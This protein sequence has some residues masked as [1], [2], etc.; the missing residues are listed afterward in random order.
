MS[1]TFI[2]SPT[3]VK[4]GPG[5]I[6]TLII[7]NPNPNSQSIILYDNTTGNPPTLLQITLHPSRSPIAIQFQ[8]DMEPKFNNGLF[9]DP[10][11]NLIWIFYT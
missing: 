6:S 10:Q 7:S 5:K 4:A 2:S 8:A 11:S 3:L 9:I 1:Q